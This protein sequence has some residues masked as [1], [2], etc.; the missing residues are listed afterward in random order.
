MNILE[1]YFFFLKLFRSFCKQQTYRKTVHLNLTDVSSEWFWIESQ[2]DGLGKHGP[3]LSYLKT[4]FVPGHIQNSV[5]NRKTWKKNQALKN[6]KIRQ[7]DNTW[8]VSKC[9]FQSFHEILQICIDNVNSSLTFYLLVYIEF[10]FIS[11]FTSILGFKRSSY[12]IYSLY[13]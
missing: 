11:H 7:Y 4:V 12:F 13:I 10:S 1:H 6:L 2:I 8:N 5:Y 9:S 3:P